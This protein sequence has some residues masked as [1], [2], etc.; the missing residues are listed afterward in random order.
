MAV[1]SVRMPVRWRGRLTVLVSVVL[2]VA[3]VAVPPGLAEAA[4][5]GHVVVADEKP[6][7]VSVVKARVIPRPVQ[8]V[9]AAPHATWP[10]AA[11]V[12]AT[13]PAPGKGQTAVTAGTLPMKVAAQVGGTV[14]KRLRIAV[15]AHA[16]A[17]ALGIHGAVLSLARADGKTSAGKV[18]AV[19][20]YTS[21]ADAYGGDYASRLHLVELPGCA[22]T[23]PRVA[24]CRKKSPL[25]TADDVKTAALTATVAVAASA[26]VLA[27]DSTASGSGGDYTAA[28]LPTTGEWTAGGSDGSFDY[29][30]PIDVP[31]VPGSLEPSVSLAYDSQSTD[32]LTSSTDNQASWV[33]DGWD[34]SPGYIERD[35]QSCETAPPSETKWAASGDLCWSKYDTITLSL[36]GQDTE[37]VDDSGD[38]ADDP[39]DGT[40]HPQVDNGEKVSYVT[41][42]SNG[43]ADGGYW[44][45]TT[46]NGTSY[47]FGRGEIA[48]YASG[49][50]ATDSA[51]TVPVYATST[52]QPGFSASKE[53]AE[54]QAWRWNLDYVTDTHGDAMAYFYST[55]D[56]YYDSTVNSSAGDADEKYVQGGAL[57]KIEYG[58]R[59]GDVYGYTPAGE[60]TFTTGTARTDIPSDMT[61]TSGDT[62]DT[63]SPTFWGKYELDDITTYA[64]SGTAL[65]EVDTWA[66]GHEYLSTGDS[67]QAAPLWLESVTETAEDGTAI[68]LPATDFYGTSF[69]NRIESED[70]DGYSLIYRNRLTEIVSDTGAVTT[71]NYQSPAGACVRDPAGSGREHTALLPGL[72]DR[73]RCH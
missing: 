26:V 22:L 19:I 63:E 24:A 12:T 20:G 66:L 14:V 23:T 11:A 42:G 15:A 69:Q 36:N 34:Y 39:A 72:L 45:I 16:A 17:T 59:A 27:A 4:T 58:L 71:V 21:F 44:V 65:D 35:Y 67:T 30:F 28:A 46:S 37:L 5:P 51:W 68:T 7:P 55:E 50:T 43:T 70:D 48:N 41:G 3:G 8:K 32:G 2:L 56:N 18:K 1:A 62:C 64:R 49:D 10:R 60:V 31:T 61:C 6:V 53:T 29:N 40:W 54:E 52:G 47:W 33:G 25:A 38:G 57:T 13:L 73:I 9:T